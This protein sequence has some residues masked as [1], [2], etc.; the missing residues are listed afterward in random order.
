MRLWGLSVSDLAELFGVSH[1][2]AAAWLDEGVPTEHAQQANDMKA[3]SDLLEQHLKPGR[4][5][6]VVR[7][8][9][10]ALGGDSLLSMIAAGRSIE[11]L[12]LTRQMFAFQ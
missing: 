12:V 4:I 1:Q 5:P 11:A 8:T 6:V 7:Q 2:E 10:P 3:V 9:A